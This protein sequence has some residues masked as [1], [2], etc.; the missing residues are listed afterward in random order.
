MGKKKLTLL[1]LLIK[2]RDRVNRYKIPSNI[3]L[4]NIAM[5]ILYG[6]LD[7]L[8]HYDNAQLL[9]K[10]YPKF[11]EWIVKEGMRLGKPISEY[12]NYGS[13][14]SSYDQDLDFKSVLLNEFI[15]QIE[16]ELRN[17]DN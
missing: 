7:C 10:D 9:L 11:T 5:S 1:E 12:Y 13:A 17:E 8:N 14:W 4:C 15:K 2:I 16:Q 3:F 6:K